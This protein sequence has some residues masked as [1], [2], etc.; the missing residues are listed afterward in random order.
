MVTVGDFERQGLL[1]GLRLYSLKTDFRGLDSQSIKKLKQLS[2][3]YNHP[4]IDQ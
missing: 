2:G 1:E 4:S 3:R